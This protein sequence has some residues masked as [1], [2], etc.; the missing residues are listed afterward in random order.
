MKEREEA[1]CTPPSILEFRNHNNNNQ[2]E[3]RIPAPIPLLPDTCAYRWIMQMD[4][5]LW[6]RSTL[7][8]KGG[9]GYDGRATVPMLSDKLRNDVVNNE[10]AD[11]IDILNSDF[12]QVAK[13]PQL[14]L[15]P[16]FF[17][18]ERPNAQVEWY[19][20]SECQ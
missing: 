8:E 18:R 9:I 19:Y 13:Y 20:I 10:S 16:P 5:K 2:N 6:R 14:D 17:F 12:N 3:I 7:A 11:I 1:G 15:S 4:A